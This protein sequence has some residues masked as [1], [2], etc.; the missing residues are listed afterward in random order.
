M[1][2]KG[3]SIIIVY[4][5]LMMIEVVFPIPV[6][7]NDHHTKILSMDEYGLNIELTLPSF[8]LEDIQTSEGKFQRIHLDDWAR[9]YEIGHPEL[10]VKGLLIQAPQSGE[11]KVEVVDNV[12]ETIPNCQICPVPEQVMSEGGEVTDRFIKDDDLYD[13]LRLLPGKLTEI[14]TRGI[15]RGISVARLRIYPFQWNP[16]TKELRYYTKLH[17][18]VIFEDPLPRE[19]TD[20]P[21]ME[22]MFEGVAKKVIV[23]Y[24]NRDKVQGTQSKRLDVRS[25]TNKGSL[26]IEV[27]QDGIYQLTYEDL[28]DAG[29]RPSRIEPASFRLFNQGEEVA[30]KV[31]MRRTG[32]FRRGDSI[33][34]FGKG[35]DNI[36]TDTNVYWLSWGETTGKRMSEIDGTISGVG[37]KIDAFHERL[38]V[39]ENHIIWQQTPEAPEKDFW[40]WEKIT[41]PKISEFSIDIPSMASNQDK[42]MIRVGFRGRSTVPPDPNHHTIISLNGTLIGE[43]FWH[44]DIEHIQELAISTDILEEGPNTVGIESPGDT[45]ADVDVINFNWIEVDYLRRLEVKDDMLAFTINGDGRFEMGINN[46]SKQEIMI[47]DVTDPLE[48]KEV[49]DFSIESDGSGQRAVFDDLISGEKRYLVLTTS[50]IRA[51]DSVVL[52]QPADL[53]NPSNGADYIIITAR[54]FIPSVEPL[55]QLHQS[56]GLRAKAVNVEDIYNEFNLGLFD[57]T[58][59]KDFLRFTFENWEQPAPTYVLFVG[60]SNT[61]YRDFLETGKENIA[62]VHLSITRELGLTPDDTWYVSVQGDDVL[63]DMLPGRISGDSQEKVAEVIDKIVRFE[64][65]VNLKPEG[66]LLVA[67]ECRPGFEAL[68]EELTGFLP[69]EFTAERAYLRTFEDVDDA[70]QAIISNIDKGMLI[71]NYVGHGAVTNWAAE[72]IFVSQDVASLSNKNDLT[73]VVTLNCLNGFFSQPFDYSL[74]EEF[75]IAKDKGAIGAFSS[76]TLGFEWEHNILNKRIFSLIFEEGNNNLGEITTQTKIDAFARGISS[77]TMISYTLF[78][79]P[80]GRLKIGD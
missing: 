72:N 54:K 32:R 79:D 17:L 28:L 12:Y 3:F 75:V 59:I 61:D 31:V 52:W 26:R 10:P 67:D 57:P 76:S 49:V 1:I 9:I 38:H 56:Q 50:Q 48:V 18:K 43:D 44:G 51:P 27:K 34:F 46:L 70:T 71:T 6:Q 5:L 74:G 21:G 62:P 80:A 4:A 14:D 39:E 42:A 22:G 69:P 19:V 60:D 11:I 24:K 58:A 66:V 16:A 29:L 23:N 53:K 47:Y 55:I 25:E 78:G 41:A 77:D 73:F 15:M 65:S 33:E 35:I 45:G 36:F 37:E 68:N 8:E 40:F 7:A 13:S 20:K 2:N 63:P 64:E 30:I